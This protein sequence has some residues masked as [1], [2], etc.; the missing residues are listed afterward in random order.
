MLRRTDPALNPANPPSSFI[1]PPPSVLYTPSP[2]KAD[3]NSRLKRTTEWKW[4]DPE[5]AVLRTPS[6][7]LIAAAAAMPPS[8]SLASLNG[9]V[10]ASVASPGPSP[11]TE[12][13]AA[14]APIAPSASKTSLASVAGLSSFASSNNLFSSLSPSSSTTPVSNPS[15]AAT[16]SAVPGSPTI[17]AAPPAPLPVGSGQ[18]MPGGPALGDAGTWAN[19]PG[20]DEEGWQYGD[21]HFEKMGPKGGLGKYTR[22]RAW[23]RRAGLVEKIERMAGDQALAEAVGKDQPALGGRKPSLTGVGQAPAPSSGGGTPSTTATARRSSMLGSMVG[24]GTNVSQRVGSL[25]DRSASGSRSPVRSASASP[26][27]ADASG[28]LTAALGGAGGADVR[29]RRSKRD[30]EGAGAGTEGRVSEEPG[31]L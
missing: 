14:A 13:G 23:V 2:T 27:K 9:T 1:L 29:R 24:L 11:V 21:N 30:K 7:Q 10:D 19:W 18:P 6:A 3:P 8:P 26:T 16:A 5:W 28:S 25:R 17:G 12:A 15:P 31:E 20:V 4:L 22:K